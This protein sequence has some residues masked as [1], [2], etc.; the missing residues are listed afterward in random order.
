MIKAIVVDDE[1]MARESLTYL[2]QKFDAIELTG[3]FES[4]I[5]ALKHLEKEPVDLVFLDVEMPELSGMELLATAKDLPEIV[6][7][8]NNPS[9]AVDAF[10]YQVLDFL[11][12]PVNYARL[13]KAIDRYT[14]K[15]SANPGREDMFVRSEG[16]FVRVA[17]DE[18][19]YA[20]TMDDYMCLYMDNKTKHIIHSTLTKL[21]ADLP[22]DK[23][24]KVHRSYVVNLSKI[25]D[26][27]D[28]TLV[29]KDI[30]IP[31]SRAFRPVLKKRLGLM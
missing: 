30:V 11:P 21:E 9:Y 17:F 14:A 15:M 7:T 25:V 19:L 16:K 29:I 8:T 24:Q 10:E 31:I 13:T 5:D 23:F 22:S 27:D 28:T 6:L 12:K 18:L 1:A 3:A 26:V 4:G 2:L 20:Q